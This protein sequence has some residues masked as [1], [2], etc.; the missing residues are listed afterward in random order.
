[1][2]DEIVHRK[3]RKFEFPHVFALLFGLIIIAAI[4]TYFVPAG[5]YERVVNEEGYNVVV[6]G[7]FKEMES[8]P[9]SPIGIIDAVYKG[10]VNGGEIIFFI[11]IVGGAFGII[12]ATKAIEVGLA[13]VS[14][15]LAGREIIIIPVV[16]VL[17]ALGGGTF[18]MSEETLPFILIL[19]PLLMRMG[20]DSLTG[21]G[22]IVI[23]SCAGFTASFLN[24]FTIGVAQGIAELPLFSGIELRL[25]L[26][27]IFVGLN[28][29]F[30]MIYANK[31]K[32]NPETSIMYEL[33]QK[34]NLED[35]AQYTNVKLTGRQSLV[36]VLLVLAIIGLAVGVLSYGWY[37]MEISSLF[38]LV[39]ILA[40][41]IAKFRVNKIAES[42]V[43]G[44]REMVAGAL[45]V[46][47]AYGVLVI[48]EES[49]II[50]TILFHLSSILS[51]IPSAFTAIGMFI[52]QALINLGVPSGSGQ[53]ALTMPIMIPLADL[54]EVNRQTAVLIFQLADGIGNIYAPTSGVLMASL[55]MARIPWTKWMRWIWPLL[56]GSYLFGAVVITLVHLFVWTA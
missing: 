55:A 43:D 38:L 40:G 10:M 51:V 39:G 46:G 6:D 33:D 3:K 49:N 24:P 14:T 45:I 16:M 2:N 20:F 48:L 23:G 44:C 30:V 37:I 42:F 7:T 52:T 12:N 13:N 11:F 54:A 26:W 19:V 9:T 17:F 25:L 1:M 4:L 32:K 53:A 18:G 56:V 8:N 21:L 36:L 28:I 50:D 29:A 47:I 22:V 41:I 5:E 31:V 15:K 27:V 35:S 34:W